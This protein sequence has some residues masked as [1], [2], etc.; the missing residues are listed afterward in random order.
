MVAALAFALAGCALQRDLS[1]I[2]APP[3][4]P[5]TPAPAFRGETIDG[6]PVALEDYAGRGVVLNF[7]GS[8]CPPCRA[9]QPGLERLSREF[10][11]QGVEFLG[12]NIRDSRGNARAYQQEFGVTYPSVFD[13]PAALAA[14]YQVSYP[15]TTVLIDRQ[16]HLVYRSVGAVREGE[17]RDLIRTRLVAPGQS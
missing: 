1:E 6:R 11:S 15:P 13:R 5:G 12:V 8:W 10:R 14:R 17:L 2:S 4:K 3:L 7:W 9:E 16:G